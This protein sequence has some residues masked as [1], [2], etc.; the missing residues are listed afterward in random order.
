MRPLLVQVLGKCHVLVNIWWRRGLC[1]SLGIKTAID[2][3]YAIVWHSCMLLECFC[4]GSWPTLQL[5]LEGGHRI[6]WLQDIGQAYLSNVASLESIYRFTPGISLGCL[7]CRG[8]CQHRLINIHRIQNHHQML[9]FSSIHHQGW[10]GVT[11]SQG[12]SYI[13]QGDL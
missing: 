4:W 5:G 10:L 2:S 7:I 13:P 11:Y 9:E 1:T 6:A 12:R 8:C 3:L